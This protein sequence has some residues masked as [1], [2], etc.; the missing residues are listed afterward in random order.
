MGCGAAEPLIRGHGT[1]APASCLFSLLVL[2][3]EGKDSEET[4]R[5]S[6]L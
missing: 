2:P 1:W 3:L 5:A 6:V 4:S